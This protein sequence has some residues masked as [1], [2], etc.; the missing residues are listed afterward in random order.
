MK[1]RRHLLAC[2]R[3]LQSRGI[4]E[5]GDSQFTCNADSD[6]TRGATYSSVSAGV[7]AAAFS[8]EPT[9]SAEA[10]TK[11]RGVEEMGFMDLERE[12]GVDLGT[13]YGQRMTQ[14]TT[15]TTFERATQAP[16]FVVT[17]RYAVRVKLIEWGVPVPEQH[18]VSAAPEPP[19]PFPAAPGYVQAPAGYRG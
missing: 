4:Q 3:S 14:Y 19:N 11:S 17:L 16:A 10:K 9:K 2:P 1:P 13:G 18:V 8:P 5:I 12:R 15:T 6:V 7:A